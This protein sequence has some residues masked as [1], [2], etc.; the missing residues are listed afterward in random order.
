MR[1]HTSRA[2]TSAT[3][4]SA[5]VGLADGG[6]TQMC[7]YG[8]GCLPRTGNGPSLNSSW[9]VVDRRSPHAGLLTEKDGDAR[10]PERS[11]SRESHAHAYGAIVSVR[12]AWVWRVSITYGP[13]SRSIPSNAT[14]DTA[15]GL[16]H[17]SNAGA[18]SSLLA[19]T[20]A[21]YPSSKRAVTNCHWPP[22]GP[23]LEA[24]R[25]P[26]RQ[27]DIR[28]LHAGGT[29]VGRAFLVPS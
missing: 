24:S 9:R 21:L 20:A 16:Q 18:R 4:A 5:P 3:S 15:T 13:I 6:M 25:G 28:T 11:N 2:A 17:V 22:L 27:H 10:W 29:G 19:F 12:G 23:T 26:S 1:V 14:F 8:T 7:S